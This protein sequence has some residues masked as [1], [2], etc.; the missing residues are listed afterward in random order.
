MLVLAS[1]TLLAFMLIVA[2]QTWPEAVLVVSFFAGL[3]MT[4]QYLAYGAAKIINGIRWIF[5]KLGVMG[6]R[7]WRFVTFRGKEQ[8]VKEALAEDK[9]PPYETSRAESGSDDKKDN[10][11]VVTVQLEGECSKDSIGDETC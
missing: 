7:V 11:V 10:G 3:I 4:L 5:K 6:A 9:P 2:F 1:F 8:K